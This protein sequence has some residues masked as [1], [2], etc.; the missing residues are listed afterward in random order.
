MAAIDAA[1]AHFKLYG[2]RKIEV[3]EWA[4]EDGSPTI[5]YSHPMTLMDRQKVSGYTEKLGVGEALAM[6]LILKAR[7]AENK[8]MFTI[9]DKHALMHNVDPNVLS[10]VVNEISRALNAEDAEAL[11]KNSE[12]ARSST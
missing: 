6:T 4:N 5:I 2:V 1:K 8:P 3:A 7:D 10:R 9:G 12:G 11:E